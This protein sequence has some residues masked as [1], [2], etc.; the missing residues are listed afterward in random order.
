MKGFYYLPCPLCQ[1]NIKVKQ[2]DCFYILTLHSNYARLFSQEHWQLQEHL[3]ITIQDLRL[4]PMETYPTLEYRQRSF[5]LHRRCHKLVEELSHLQLCR[6]IDLV[7]PTFL[8]HT[9]PPSSANGAFFTPSSCHLSRGKQF[10]ARLPAEIQDQILGYDVGRLLYVMRTA[11]QLAIQHGEN[12]KA[13]PEHRFTEETLILKGNTVRV[14]L[15]V[16]GGHTYVSHLSDVPSPRQLFWESLLILWNSPRLYIL[17]IFLS[18]L[19]LSIIFAQQWKSSSL[20]AMPALGI[21]LYSSISLGADKKMR[22]DYK[23]D[24][25][26]AVKSDEMGVID[27]AFQQADARPRW[28]LNNYACPFQAKI[29]I[30][31]CADTRRL[32]IIRDVS[33]SL[34]DVHQYH[35][36][37]MSHSP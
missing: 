3:A 26:L 16:V 20:L 8:Q 27:I 18:A 11:S 4:S 14:H 36:L 9:L 31:R 24:N 6:L 7:E 37:T 1:R 30:I 29:S 34:L 21:T 32:R 22:Q 28:I 33:N 15:V 23:P 19:L 25:Y 17:L 5:L 2:S 13:I 12:S 35:F 10:L